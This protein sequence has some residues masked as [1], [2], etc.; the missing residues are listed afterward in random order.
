LGQLRQT[1]LEVKIKHSPPLYPV[2]FGNSKSCVTNSSSP[3]YW[4]ILPR[5]PLLYFLQLVT[6]ACACLGDATRTKEDQLGKSNESGVNSRIEINEE[7]PS[8]MVKRVLSITR[9]LFIVDW[10]TNRYPAARTSLENKQ[11]VDVVCWLLPALLHQL[12][13]QF[14]SNEA[15][16]CLETIMSQLCESLFNKASGL[17]YEDWIRLDKKALNYEDK[18]VQI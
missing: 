10:L 1:E 18:N 7:C 14:E 9:A 5:P 12:V 2:A 16:F 3:A 17:G 13:S 4:Q 11:R 15:R 6:N 8:V